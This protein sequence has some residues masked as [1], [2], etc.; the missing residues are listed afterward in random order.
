MNASPAADSVPALVAANAL[1]AGAAYAIVDDPEVATDER[2][3]LVNDSLQ[4]LQALARHHRRQFNIPVLAITG[5]NGKTTTKELVASVLSAQHATHFTRGNFNN[6]IGVP[7]TL[8]AMP[9][10]TYQSAVA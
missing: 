8:L 6:H 1:A 2:Y 3:L 9:L 7:L 5:S 4:A 10:R